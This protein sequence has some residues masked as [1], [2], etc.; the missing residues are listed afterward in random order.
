MRLWYKPD[1]M[2]HVPNIFNFSFIASAILLA[3]LLS[4]T[5]GFGQLTVG[6]GQLTA[7]CVRLTVEY[8]RLAVA[9]DSWLRA[10]VCHRLTAG[11]ESL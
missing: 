7:E 9:T 4:L 11:C 3:V 10:A 5:A 8:E 1:Q 6:F 2:K